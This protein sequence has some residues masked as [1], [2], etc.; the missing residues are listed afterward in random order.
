MTSDDSICE[1]CNE[2]FEEPTQHCLPN[3][4]VVACEAT[5]PAPRVVVDGVFRLIMEVGSVG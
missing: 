5:C 2:L 1:G 3:S 4:L